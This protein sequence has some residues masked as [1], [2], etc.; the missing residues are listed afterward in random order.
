VRLEVQT[1]LQA[2][3]AGDVVRLVLGVEP[4]VVEL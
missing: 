4:A 1:A 2:I 3:R